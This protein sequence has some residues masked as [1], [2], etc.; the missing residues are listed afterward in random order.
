MNPRPLLLAALLLAASPACAQ[1]AATPPASADDGVYTYRA[2][3]RDGIGKVYMGREIAHVMGYAGMSWLERPDRETTEK[4][5]RVVE[6]LAL[7][8]DDVV[9]DVGAG[10]GYFSFRMA[11]RVPRGR[12]LAVDL[13]PEMLAVVEQ[14]AEERGITNVEPILGVVA[15]PNLPAASVDLALMV[16]AYHEFSH[17]REMMEGIVR[18]LKP[19]GRVV[20]VEYRGEDPTV[21]IKRLH[22]MTEDQVRRE[23]AAVGLVWR[24]TLGFLPQQ[25]VL[26]FEKEG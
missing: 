6:A 1:P 24:E 9:A 10:S 8:P 14:R 25:H 5:D 4:P 26:V 18:A 2:A 12:V 3:S 11:A 23:M 20:L 13:Q 15:D 17:P 7:S 16:D 19:G 22:K 21:P